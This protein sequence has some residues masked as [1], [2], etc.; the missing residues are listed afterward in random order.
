MRRVFD[1]L[2]RI[3]G[4]HLVRDEGVAV[5][6]RI[7]DEEIVCVVASKRCEGAGFGP[8]ARTPDLASWIC[9]PVMRSLALEGMLFMKPARLLA[10]AVAVALVAVLAGCA[11]A[12]TPEEERAQLNTKLLTVGDITTG[13]WSAYTDTSAETSKDKYSSGGVCAGNFSTALGLDT[14][15]LPYSRSAMFTRGSS[16]M[17]EQL[18]KVPG[19]KDVA[20]KMSAEV[21]KCEG[22]TSSTRINGAE[23]TIKIKNVTDRPDAGDGGFGFTTEVTSGYVTSNMDFR[24]TAVGDLMVVTMAR[25]GW[26]EEISGQELDEFTTAAIKKARF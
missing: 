4:W 11:P 14:E 20:A 23:S 24:Y 10:S 8:R 13:G 6:P 7:G 22:K 18:G 9:S 26:G 1:P 21:A 3:R 16:V 5:F 25:A 17:S 15:K 19:S 12:L 2:L